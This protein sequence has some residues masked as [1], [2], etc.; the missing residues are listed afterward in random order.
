MTAEEEY[1]LKTF[2]TNFSRIKEK[3]IALYG[4]GSY[5]E[6]IL[7]NVFDYNFIG[8]MDGFKTD[9][10]FCGYD[11]LDCDGIL[12][13]DTEIIII[14]ARSNN[15]KIIYNRIADFCNENNIIAMNIYGEVLLKLQD[16]FIEN[17]EYFKKNEDEL[18]KLID[19]NEV[20]S[21]DIFDTLIM[22]YTLLPDDVFE[23]IERKKGIKDFAK[24]RRK[25]VKYSNADIY[26]IYDE[27]QKNMGITDEEKQKLINFEVETERTVL[28]PRHKMVEMFNYA[29]SRGKP[30]YLIS[31]MYLTKEILECVLKDLGIEGYKNV[32]VSC[33][34][35][36]LKSQGLFGKYKEIVKAESYLHI[37]DNLE[38]DGI[39]AGINGISFYPIKSAYEM[40]NISSYNEAINMVKSLSD[41]LL[42]GLF[43]AE[44]F[45]NPFELYNS[46]GK[47]K[48]SSAYKRS[49]LFFAPLISCFM[50]WLINSVKNSELDGIF[51][52]ARDG[53]L[54]SKLYEKTKDILGAE[55]PRGIY[56]LISRFAGCIA[57]ATDEEDIEYFSSYAYI[58][59]PN[60]MLKERFFISPK[61]IIDYGESENIKKYVLR[62]KDEIIKIAG[63]MRKNYLKYI[64]N[65]GFLNK[66][67]IAFFDFVS[68][69][70]CQ[71]CLNKLLNTESKGFY[72]IHI[73]SDYWKKR[74]LDIRALYK[75]GNA[76][77]INN[78]LFDNYLLLEYIMASFEPTLRHFDNEGKPVF[79]KDD[80]TEDEICII[81]K[82]QEAI[83]QYYSM[84]LD[85]FLV[86]D[87]ISVGLADMLFGFMDKKYSDICDE[88]PEK[89][90]LKGEFSNKKLLLN[91]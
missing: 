77:E 19:E 88:F 17:N 50:I 29:I 89:V 11:I 71:M 84:Y 10:T 66:K 13:K 75:A 33:E 3:R 74:V 14:I 32:F 63:K 16:S 87:D 58:G 81:K 85:K 37:G 27:Y 12:A 53:Y 59:N 7:K 25:S 44:A 6:V 76:F 36:M 61:E 24:I 82:V 90:M 49:Y 56:F 45:N 4:T 20:I 39:Y 64:D 40:M 48:I 22:R 91:T 83:E 72:F 54:I 2:N 86:F 65:I 5:T 68:S 55:L 21:F 18:K 26:E 57:C 60:D 15:T 28:T 38:A 78:C 51:F 30:V 35:K 46:K 43:M 52:G 34:Y 31:D 79:I 47:L 1:V 9:G 8:V 73:I 67:N 69:G 42:L 70:T 80:R 62:Y 41:R 23:L